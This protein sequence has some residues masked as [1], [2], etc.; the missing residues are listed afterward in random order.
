MAQEML[1]EAANGGTPAVPRRR[2]VRAAGLYVIEEGGDR[3]RVESLQSERREVP[4]I[5]LC[6]ELK[7][8]L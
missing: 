4:V 1:E 2:R 5:A 8:Q 3:V 7:Q 6:D